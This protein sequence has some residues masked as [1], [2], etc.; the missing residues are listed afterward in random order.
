MSAI[1]EKSPLSGPPHAPFDFDI[2]CSDGTVSFN[3]GCLGTHSPFFAAML[4]GDHDMKEKQEKTM[5]VATSATAIQLIADWVHG[6]EP[7][8]T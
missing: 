7:P 1:H 2:V 4:F 8:S 6:A 3:S 5:P